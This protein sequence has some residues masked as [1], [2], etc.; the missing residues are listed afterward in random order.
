MGPGRAEARRTVTATSMLLFP[1][2]AVLSSSNEGRSQGKVEAICMQELGFPLG[3]INSE[4][5]IKISLSYPHCVR[6]NAG[7]HLSLATHRYYVAAGRPLRKS[8][9]ATRVPPSLARTLRGGGMALPGTDRQGLPGKSGVRTAP[10]HHNVP[11]GGDRAQGR[12][13]KTPSLGR[14]PLKKLPAHARAQ[15][16]L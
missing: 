14:R 9:L 11:A 4:S 16:A 12:R 10:T 7:S 1:P 8:C 3:C 13:G 6:A 5:Y 15:V 2:P